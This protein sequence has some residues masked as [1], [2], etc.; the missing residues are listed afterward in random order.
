MHFLI[1]TCLKLDD[2]Q[3]AALQDWGEQFE[4]PEDPEDC[5]GTGHTFHVTGSGIGDS[6]SVSHRGHHFNVGYNDDGTIIG[7]LTDSNKRCEHETGPWPAGQK[8]P[9]CLKCEIERL[10]AK[11][12]HANRRI[13]HL[14]GA[15]RS[16]AVET[17]R[18]DELRR[19]ATRL[20][21]AMRRDRWAGHDHGYANDLAALLN[22]GSPLS[23]VCKH[24]S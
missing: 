19:R 8:W 20:I 6:I 3:I 24:D 4:V 10:R 12:E 2:E 23:E 14:D 13:I 15:L 7:E 17:L 18:D 9:A 16:N 5:C 11:L 1:P 22:V 21:V